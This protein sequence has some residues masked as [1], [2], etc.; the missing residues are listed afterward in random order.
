M[1]EK[2]SEDKP[3]VVAQKDEFPLCIVWCPIPGLTW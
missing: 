1:A 3:A 2:I